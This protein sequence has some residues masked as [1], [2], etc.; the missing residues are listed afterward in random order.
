MAEPRLIIANERNRVMTNL[1]I[2]QAAEVVRSDNR[3]SAFATDLVAAFDQYGK[4]LSGGRS[5][6]LLVLA[7]QSLD[8]ANTP[9]PVRQMIGSFD[10]IVTLFKLAGTRLKFPKVELDTADG[11][12]VVLALAGPNSRYSGQINVTSGHKYGDPQGRFYGRI[13][14][15]GTTA[16]SDQGV[17]ELLKRFAGDPAGVAAEYGRRVGQCCFCRLKLTDERSLAV[18]YGPKC[19]ESW[20]LPWGNKRQSG[21]PEI[22]PPFEDE[23][24]Q[25]GVGPHSKRAQETDLT[26]PSPDRLFTID[27]LLGA[28]AGMAIR[29]G[30]MSPMA[31]RAFATALDDEIQGRDDD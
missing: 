28:A 9:E 6:W 15:D 10:A 30:Y 14:Q 23:A 17:V 8:R 7:Q 22:E 25:H 11:H 27:D 31:E 16:V 1:S 29:D 3:R 20:D 19:A 12:T 13:S 24:D 18:G 4:T 26:V 2:A 21:T 5:A